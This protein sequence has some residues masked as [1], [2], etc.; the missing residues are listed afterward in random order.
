MIA[1]DRANDEYDLFYQVCEWVARRKKIKLKKPSYIH[2]P[3]D[4]FEY[5]AQI[6][7]A[8]NIRIR[9]ISLES[10]WWKK[11]SGPLVGFYQNQACALL[12]KNGGGYDIVDCKTQKKIKLS[13]ENA[14]NLLA[15]G[16]YLYPPLPH[17]IKKLN[18]F[19]QWLL[20]NCKKDLAIALVAQLLISLWIL[21]LP[22]SFILLLDNAILR[23]DS[24]LMWQF[25]LLLFINFG[26][27]ILFNGAKATL[28]VR[29][30][31]KIE[32]LVTPSVW[33]KVLRFSLGFYRR[34]AC[35]E[36]AFR[37]NA[38]AD[39]HTTFLRS[40]LE[41]SA[42]VITV[43]LLLI[44]LWIV[45]P[46]LALLALVLILIFTAMT[47]LIISQQ[48][49]STGRLYHYF[50]QYLSFV[51]EV[52]AAIGKI[53][54]T[55]SMARVLQIWS[56]LLLHRSR[57]ELGVKYYGLYQEV[58][59]AFMLIISP[60]LL[61][62]FFQLAGITL[63]LGKLAGGFSAYFLLLHFLRNTFSILAETVRL[64]PL[65]K[66][67]Q[68]V[69]TTAVEAEKGTYDPGELSGQMELKNIV[70]RYRHDEP[71]FFK[72]LSL[73][74]HPG[75]FVAVVGPSGSGKS[76]LF[77]ILLGF[78]E[79]EAGAIYFNGV[80]LSMLKLSA[81]RKQIGIVIQSSS[82]IPGSIYANI[83][84]NY[85]QLTRVEAWQIAE[86]VGLTEFIKNLPMQ[87]DTLISEGAASLSGGEAQRII[88]AR[89]L[90]QKPKILMLDEATS[91][92]DNTT[93]ALVQA[94]LRELRVTQLIAA[95]R[96]STIV[97]AD[98]IM[99]MDQGNIVQIG[100]FNQLM[101]QPGL[102]SQMAKRQLS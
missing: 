53:R 16:F 71:P 12:P 31:Y 13:A 1:E 63:S 22:V 33:D 52:I 38:I 42:N 74:I 41:I 68:I 18:Q 28:S 58:F 35:G 101:A 80:N 89:A 14:G 75:E 36:T 26:A 60:L 19:F 93:Q 72:N 83:A 34:F 87:L 5:A 40:L 37:I 3:R 102:F 85:S 54:V 39:I 45:L 23:H 49:R 78:E 95:H 4:L 59:S 25:L 64:L 6:S 79:P 73:A 81:L 21:I 10:D 48:M 43:L 84:G 8:A 98:R 32:S 29:L 92:L 97:H 61:A 99:V 20:S 44:F 11:D 2:Q 96:L 62:L 90:A 57:S 82:L 51:L 76:T 65:W 50:G 94:Y 66:K 77:R 9:K 24:W 30:H 69:F 17:K 88:L 91:A 70:F 46:G 86:K 27:F 55:D 100:T 47:L 15:Y 67:S 7:E 56:N